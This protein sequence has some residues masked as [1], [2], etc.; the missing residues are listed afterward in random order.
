MTGP[1]RP[2]LRAGLWLLAVTQA[3]VGAWALALPRLFFDQFPAPGHPWVAL[4]P[5]Y[6]E[7]LTFDHG[8]LTLSL[9][10]VFL[11]AALSMERLLV[12]TALTANLVFAG[13]HF[14]YHALRLD[15]FPP[16]DAAAQTALLTVTLV[17]SGALLVLAMLRGAVD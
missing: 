4:L 7:H 2:W 9:A 6:N 10:V 5:S 13:P 15:G 11:V 8:A 17:I 1:T 12:R 3:A 16:G 14:V